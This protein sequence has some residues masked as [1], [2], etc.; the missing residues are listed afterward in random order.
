MKRFVMGSS[1]NGT[2][3]GSIMLLYVGLC[4]AVKTKK[5]TVPTSYKIIRYRKRLF[6]ELGQLFAGFVEHSKSPRGKVLFHNFFHFANSWL[7]TS[8]IQPPAGVD[9]RQNCQNF[10]EFRRLSQY[11]IRRMYICIENTLPRLFC[12]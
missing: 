4:H 11:D 5:R 7:Q 1:S 8:R 9:F 2:C 12:L 3:F 10:C 6:C